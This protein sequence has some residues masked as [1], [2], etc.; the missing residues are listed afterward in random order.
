M[1]ESCESVTA[2]V[3]E[4]DIHDQSDNDIDDQQ[5]QNSDHIVNL[6]NT[7]QNDLTSLS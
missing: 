2:K 3:D 6:D 7:T 1:S 4:D 5:L